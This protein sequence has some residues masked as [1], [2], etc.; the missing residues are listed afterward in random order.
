MFLLN[1]QY[2]RTV[3]TWQLSNWVTSGSTYIPTTLAAIPIALLSFSL[4]VSVWLCSCLPSLKYTIY[5]LS[6]CLYQQRRKEA[7]LSLS[8]EGQIPEIQTFFL[9]LFLF[10]KLTAIQNSQLDSFIS[11][12]LCVRASTSRVFFSCSMPKYIPLFGPEMFRRHRFQ[13]FI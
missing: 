11:W 5:L 13:Q 9:F 8:A 6:S 1:K 12:G 3:H 2:L 7:S 10:R 4:S